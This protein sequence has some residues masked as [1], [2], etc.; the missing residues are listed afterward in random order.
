MYYKEYYIKICLKKVGL[1]APG[2]LSR[3][4]IRL[5]ILAQVMTSRFTGQ[6]SASGSVLTA[7]SLPGILSL[8][9]SLPLPRLHTFSLF[10]C[11]HAFSLSQNK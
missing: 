10:P 5:L 2:W 9:L 6:S 1:G 11:L 3:L 7:R 4:S 8:P